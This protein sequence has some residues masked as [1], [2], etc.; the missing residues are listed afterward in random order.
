MK[1][2]KYKKEANSK[3]KV[4]L[5][6]GSTLSFYEEVLLKF[7]LLIQKEIDQQTLIEADSYNQECD[8]YY[9]ALNSIKS[10][11]KSTYELKMW[12]LKKEYSTDLVDKAIEKLTEQ[13]YLSDENYAKSY[14]NYQLITTNKGP[15]RIARELEEKKIDSS[16]IAEEIQNFSEEEQKIRIK[17]II[18]KGI[19]KNHTRGGVVLKQKIVN[20]LK[21]LGYDFSLIQELIST[22]SFSNDK[23]LAKKEYEKLLKK[24]SRKYQG[25]ELKRKIEQQLYRKGLCYEQE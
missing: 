9:A 7:N 22:Y 20:D 12:L 21:G 3:Y 10:R 19:E 15:Y 14:L 23:D 11:L 4:F 8:V 17:K 1:I 2:V 25:E 18:E 13:G 16:V 24:Y 5:E 6:D